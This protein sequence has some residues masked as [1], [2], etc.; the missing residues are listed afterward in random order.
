[1]LVFQPLPILPCM[2]HA[3]TQSSLQSPGLN[4]ISQLCLEKRSQ[5][6][7]QKI[8]SC[9]EE[10]SSE[11]RS[12]VFLLFH[13]ISVCWGGTGVPHMWKS[14]DFHLAGVGS[15]CPFMWVPE[16]KLRFPGLAANAD[17]WRLQNSIFN[18]MF[19]NDEP[20]NKLNYVLISC[21]HEYGMMCMLND[22]P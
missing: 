11:E 4:T 13:L 22:S 20:W 18:L 6:S 21:V 12:P 8:L 1:M 7:M 2:G 3:T 16:I 9:L 5:D 14:E 19:L 15:F 10:V 17:Q